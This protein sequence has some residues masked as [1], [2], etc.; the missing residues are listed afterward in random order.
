MNSFRR[1]IQVYHAVEALYGRF[2][3]TLDVERAYRRYLK[4]TGEEERS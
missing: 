2:A 1:F 3:S 4:M